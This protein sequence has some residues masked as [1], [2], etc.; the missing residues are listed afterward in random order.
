MLKKHLFIFL[1]VVPFTL[2][3]QTFTGSGGIIPDNNVIASFAINVPVLS[4]NVVN[5]N[6]G[7]E[8][9]CLNI[10]HP[11]VSDLEVS[12]RAPDGTTVVLF[13][14][15][16]GNGDNF[17]NT[18]LR[19]NVPIS[20][21][22][23]S[24]PFTGTFK[25]QNNMSIVN[26]GQNANGPW[27]LRVRDL[28]A[29]SAGSLASWSITFGNQPAQAFS[30]TSSDLP[31][32]LI[33]TINNVPIPDEPKVPALMKIIYNG[34]GVRNYL[35]DTVFHYNGSAGIETRGSSSQGMPKKS[36]GFETRD[37]Q[38][39]NLNV[40]LLGMPA[41]N[42]WILSANYS[43]KTLFRNALTYN[44]ANKT[45]Q[46]APR[47]RFCEIMLN[48]EYIGVYTLTEK[49]KR[50][51]GRVNVA[52]LNS[53]DTT[54]TELTGGYILKI[55]KLTGAGGAGWSSAFPPP[56]SGTSQAEIY[57][58]YDY[59][60][61]DSI[62]PAQAQYIKNFVD[63]FEAV[64][65]SPD[66]QN[67][68]NGWRQ[69][70]DEPSVIDFMLMNELSRNVDGY[71][72]ST[73]LHKEKITRGNKLKMGPVWDFDIAWQNA[74]YCQGQNTTGWAY[75]FNA[76]C[77][78]GGGLLVPFWWQRFRQD[79]LFNK[80]LYCRYQEFRNSFLSPSALNSLAD[81]M[82]LVLNESQERNFQRWSI[83][84]V[85]VWPNPNPI[86]TTY[87]GE[88]TKLKQWFAD[89]L[90]WI[91]GQITPINSGYPTVD[92][93]P[94]TA[95][96]AGEAVTLSP[97]NAFSIL[98]NTGQTD[99]VLY[100]SDAG[101]YWVELTNL[102]GCKASDTIQIQVKANPYVDFSVTALSNFQFQFNSAAQ[103]GTSHLWDF[104]DG[105]GSQQI[106][107]IH[108][109]SQAGAYPVELWV[110]DTAGCSSLFTQSV[111]TQTMGLFSVHNNENYISPN[112]VKNTFTLFCDKCVGAWV[113]MYSAEGRK[114]YQQTITAT[115]EIFDISDLPTGMYILQIKQPGFPAESIKII[116]Q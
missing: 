111:Q 45:R 58:Q 114:L 38:G 33:N 20:I 68:E 21:I 55:D 41:E 39:N 31:I 101:N 14:G 22:T 92:L 71:R 54:G 1:N 30:F 52:E 96:C 72:I 24:A 93:G 77:G 34:E 105:N 18:C 99:T 11:N 25:P 16:G 104:G 42:D 37:A 6:F 67:P 113:E 97:G 50:D 19:Q 27:R 81:S 56:N 47:T 110:T 83:L 29:Q 8:Q 89:R 63:S 70:M 59:P 61:P 74:N 53:W 17:S 106:N 79:S 109:Y 103:P 78:G 43:D 73:F 10:N 112:L 13:S 44:L 15:I 100:A 51:S 5:T 4:P 26:N 60:S 36:F 9:I 98:W 40:S 88:V 48:G 57:F 102:Y 28:Y 32:V 116:I 2:T 12:L 82:A 49:I 91:D 85:Y 76:V 66:F 107:P 84:G 64:L 90:A 69:F 115:T 23:G 80:R 62:H 46:Y 108:T 95:I 75:D 65:A 87:I 94:D 3:A 7:V 86:P 35:T